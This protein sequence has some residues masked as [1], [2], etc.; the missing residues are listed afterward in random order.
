MKTS[1]GN[2]LLSVLYKHFNQFFQNLVQTRTKISGLDKPF[3][4]DYCLKF[5]RYGLNTLSGSKFCRQFHWVFFNLP[6]LKAKS[7]QWA[8]S[9]CTDLQPPLCKVIILFCKTCGSSYKS[10]LWKYLDKNLNTWN[11]GGHWPEGDKSGGCINPCQK[12]MKPKASLWPEVCSDTDVKLQTLF[13]ADGWAPVPDHLN[14]LYR[15]SRHIR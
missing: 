13:S 6:E 12:V 3:V 15:N 4:I 9:N 1:G 14:Q 7:V 10:W 8:E 2:L 5:P 11:E